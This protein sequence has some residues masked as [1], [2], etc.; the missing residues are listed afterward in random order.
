MTDLRINPDRMLRNLAQLS[1]FGATGDGGVHRPALSETHLAARVWLCAKLEAAGLEFFTDA[2]G[3]HFGRLACGPDGAASLLIGS[4][5]DSVPHGGRFD[6][7]LGVVAGLEVLET[8]RDT[9]LDLACHLEVV[10][11]TDE[12]GTLVGLLGSRALAGAL[13]PADLEN[14]RGG[15]EAL[16]DGFARAGITDPTAAA[17]DPNT[18]AGYLELHIEQ[19]PR[20]T[21]AQAA[22]GIV[23]ALVG[24]GSF[25]L[26]FRGRADHAGTTPMDARRDAGLGAAQ[27]MVRAH[28]HVV[29]NYPG[30]VINFGQAEF[31]PGAYNIVPETAS[32]SLEYRAESQDRLN[33]LERDLLDI[34]QET[35]AIFNLQLETHPQ[36]CVA[37]APC[38]PVVR[39]AFA[40]ACETL[41]L[42]SM[43]LVSGAGHD[44]QAMTSVCPAGMIFIPSAGGSHNPDEFAES[45]DCENG[46]NVLLHTALTLAAKG[47]F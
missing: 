42:K 23:T 22:I 25:A 2:A 40:A 3:N 17:R 24:I 41:D 28:D 33:A 19:G 37:P 16:A 45:E 38:S 13:T 27:L 20:L 4:H 8:I 11:F 44:T 30:A 29:S 35:A 1:E 31:L 10:D 14:P 18:L 21:A 12:E 7:A 36:G 9:G 39:S 32:I 46:A 43:D 5:L 15:R 34:A 26:A 47:D 6:G